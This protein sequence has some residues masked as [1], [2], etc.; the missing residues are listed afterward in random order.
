[1][2]A[3]RHDRLRPRRRRSGDWS[4]AVEAR[5]VNGRNLEARFKARRAS[6]AWSARP[7]TARRPASS[8]ARSASACRPS[9]PRPLRARSASTSTSS[10][11]IIDA[12]EAP[13]SPQGAGARPPACDGLLALRGVVEAGEAEEDARGPGGA[14]RRP[15][16]P[17]SSAA[18][19][20]LKAARLEEGAA[21]ARVLAGLVDRIE[22]LVAGRRGRSRAR[23]PAVSR[24]ASPAAWP[25]WL[26]DG[27]RCSEDRI[28]AGGRRPGRQRR[29]ARGA[30]PAGRPRRRGPRPDR[31][32][33]RRRAAGW[34]S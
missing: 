1:M 7:A 2:P 25:S 9:A 34:T 3:L 18:L 11:A 8:A 23:P 10:T 13:M 17:P 6:T 20:G 19:D 21:L 14:W 30:R 22:A 31:R 16:R 26:G 5:S 24:T 33:R 15:W 27:R 29:R 32:R 28:V 12:V 4:W